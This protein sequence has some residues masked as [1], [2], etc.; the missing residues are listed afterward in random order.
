MERAHGDQRP[1]YGEEENWEEALETV[2]SS[3]T[4]YHYPSLNKHLS[5]SLFLAVLRWRGAVGPWDQ[6]G[7]ADP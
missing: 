1:F 5:L 4:L 7:V 6:D 2:C 3:Y